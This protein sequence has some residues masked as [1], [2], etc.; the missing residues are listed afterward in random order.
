[1]NKIPQILIVIADGTEEI[2]A[3][4]PIDL[5]RRAGFDVSVAGEKHIVVC[6]RGTKIVS[7]LLLNEVD[8]NEIYDLIF[9]PGG[10]KGTENL[11]KNQKLDLLLQKQIISNRYVAAICAAP[12][13]LSTKG[14]L[15][16]DVSVTS[17]PSVRASFRDLNY[18][19]QD[20]VVSGKV[21]TS[22]G[23]GT[24]VDMALKIIEILK[25]KELARKIANDIVYGYYE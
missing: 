21:I 17:H 12:T 13:I 15:N 10:S 24:A 22:R 23:A 7:D 11:L 2:E 16:E 6:S 25:S 4:V 5:F 14:F 8:S 19:E 1:M 18:V 3:V 9:I 20:T